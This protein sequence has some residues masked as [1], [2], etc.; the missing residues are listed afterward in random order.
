MLND[1]KMISNIQVKLLNAFQD[2]YIFLIINEENRDVVVVDPGESE[3]VLTYLK[4]HNLTLKSIYLTHH[5]KDHIAG[6]TE[7]QKKYNCEVVGFFG[8]IHRLPPL[9]RTVKNE[10]LLSLWGYSVVVHHTPGHTT[11]H[12]IYYIPDMKACFVGDTLFSMGCGRLFE[13]TSREMHQSLAFIRALPGETRIY[14][15]HEYTLHNIEFAK[16]VVKKG[17]DR[18]ALLS[19]EL[20]MKKLRQENIPTI[21]F[22]LED[23]LE[24][25]PFFAVASES[26]RRTCG[27]DSQ[28][29]LDAFSI[30]RQRRDH[31]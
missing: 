3:P 24:L 25:N 29:A 8:D 22:I 15:A 23:Q 18:D 7:L 26:Y 11:G 6:V 12:I 2:N 10:D 21:P 31:F 1:S 19:Y 16:T 30:L 28:S 14:C 27:P 20:S 9:T 5:H 13:G 17:L 4:Q